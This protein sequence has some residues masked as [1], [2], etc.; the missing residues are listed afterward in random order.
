VYISRQV[1]TRLAAAAEGLSVDVVR[2]ATLDLNSGESPTQMT[3]LWQKNL[4]GIRAERWWDVTVLR[5]S[6]VA[7]LSSVSYSG[8]SPA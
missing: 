4:V 1:W 3:N 2:N 5:S 6:A 8:G 7:S